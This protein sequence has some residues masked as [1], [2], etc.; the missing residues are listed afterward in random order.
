MDAEK[1]L[2]NSGVDP[3]SLSLK[4]NEGKLVNHPSRSGKVLLCN[5]KYYC[6]DTTYDPDSEVGKC[7]K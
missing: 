5:R 3:L 4:V 7:M 1:G 6:I 2:S